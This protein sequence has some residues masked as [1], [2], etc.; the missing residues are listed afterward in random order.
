MSS[1]TVVKLI[2]DDSE[3]PNLQV[4]STDSKTLIVG[5]NEL[6][7]IKSTRCARQQV[8]LHIEDDNHVYIEQLGANTSFVNEIP[9]DSKKRQLLHD[10]DKLQLVENE[11]CYTIRIDPYVTVQPT[12]K[13]QNTD[14]NGAQQTSM[15]RPKPSANSQNVEDDDDD[16]SAEEN[17]LA[18]IQQ[19]LNA[20]QENAT[21][22]TQPPS[23][24]PSVT[25]ATSKDLWEKPYKGL[26][27]FT[28]KGVISS[29]KIAAF[30]MDGTIILTKSG[31]VHPTDE[32][33]WRIGFDTCF[34]KLKQLHTDHYKIVVFTNQRGLMK[35][36]STDNFRKKIQFIQQKLNVPMQVFVAIHPGRYRKPCIG[37]W[38]LLQSKYN[39]GIQIDKSKSFY[40]GDAAGRP[41]KW[42][43]KAKKDHSCAD[44]LFAINVGLKFY[45]P[46][47]YFLGLNK[48][49][50]E[51]PKFEPKALR[52][53]LSLVEPTTGSLTS[54]KV[55]LIVMCGLPASGK[56]WFVKKHIVSHKYEYINRDEVGTWQKC[57]KMAETAL[58]K[59]QSAIIDN[60][61]LDKESRQRYVEVAKKFQVPCRCFIMNVSL[62]HA[63]HNNLFRQMIGADDAHKDVNDIVIMGANKRYVK[64]TLDE[65]FSEILT[66]NMQPL[67]DDQELEELYYQYI[68]DK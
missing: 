6:S 44:R 35:A 34:K 39:D 67:F 32:N 9:I 15:K 55:E 65:G 64:P 37:S 16:D 11:H 43:A 47:E 57:V 56:S 49:N 21:Q 31:K 62:E 18:W 19:Q 38:L 12:L 4:Q 40:V 5:R 17:R 8:A 27:V 14:D 25:T 48:A 28:S 51:M 68:L 66:I 1:A 50:Y 53:I 42:R 60:T 24:L 61:N 45:T 23:Q 20:L 63:K 30:D 13:R 3:Y 2:S 46:E 36:A 29:E 41:D 59:Q 7:K 54:D 33:D 26:E 22:P 10:G 58:S 52:S